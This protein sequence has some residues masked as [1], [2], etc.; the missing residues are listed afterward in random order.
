MSQPGWAAQV[1]QQ[2]R[3]EAVFLTN[4]FDDPLEGFD[5]RVYVPCLRTDDLVFQLAR[6]EVRDRLVRATGLVATNAATLRAALGK[7]FTH[8][9][10]RNARACAIS[11][12]PDFAPRGSRRGGLR[13]RWRRS[14]PGDSTPTSRIARLWASSCSGP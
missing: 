10:A 12:P 2:S 8:F 11:L 1:L 13:R 4:E 14:G 6:P 5:T 7:L 9:A 3:L